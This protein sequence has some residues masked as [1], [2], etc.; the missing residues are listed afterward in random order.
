MFLHRQPEKQR[1]RYFDL[2]RKVAA[3]SGLCTESNVDSQTP[4][5][6]YRTH[7]IIFSNS[8]SVKSRTREDIS[9]DAQQDSLGIGLK[10]FN[11]K[12]KAQM[13]KIAEFNKD[14]SSYKEAETADKARIISELYN[15]RI[16]D[17]SHLYKLEA[18]SFSCVAK[19][20]GKMLVFDTEMELI[21]LKKLRINSSS[22]PTKSIS[23]SDG[24]HDYTFSSSKSTL[25]RRFILPSKDKIFVLKVDILRDPLSFLEEVDF[26][27][28]VCNKE[29]SFVLLP[30]SSHERSGL[31]Q[32]N[33][34]GRRRGKSDVYVPR[35]MSEVYVPI[36]KWI[37]H[38]FQNFF[39]AREV[40]FS[41]NLPNGKTLSAKICQEGGKALMSNPNK[42][43]GNWLLREVL[44][45]PE[46]HVLTDRY[47]QEKGIDSIK[48]TKISSRAFDIDYMPY[49]SF[50]KFSS[51]SQAD[52]RCM[53]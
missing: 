26:R 25:K 35:D 53:E 33:A 40:E 34:K 21:N 44:T 37:H 15:R 2:L 29:T 30:L 18:F 7:E 1:E 11:Y 45:I 22:N 41:L 8:F 3:L 43:L 32:W 46:G 42:A 52:A 14:F 47:L 27:R 50:E 17:A 36:P 24:L 13:E 19:T 51:L 31:N 38:Y 9:I 49:G 39:P 5:L 16:N 4:Y 28:H 20:P 6:Y 23:F 48:V 10:T 12:G